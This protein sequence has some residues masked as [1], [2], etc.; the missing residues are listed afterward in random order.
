MI[1]CFLLVLLF[2]TKKRNSYQIASIKTVNQYEGKI[3][4][5]FVF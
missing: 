4:Q 2:E 1:V 3:K 5:R